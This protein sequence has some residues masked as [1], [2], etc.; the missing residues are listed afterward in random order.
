MTS[1]EV[2][3]KHVD[4]TLILWEKKHSQFIPV[5]NSV[6]GPENMSLNLKIK[7]LTKMD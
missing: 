5:K 1:K 2:L 4:I 6:Y 7:S 3:V